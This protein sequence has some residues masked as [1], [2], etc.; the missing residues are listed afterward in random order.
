[1]LGPGPGCAASVIPRAQGAAARGALVVSR[2]SVTLSH[3]LSA[4]IGTGFHSINKMINKPEAKMP[5]R[6]KL[7]FYRRK[8]AALRKQADCLSSSC[9]YPHCVLLRMQA[10]A[11][12][13]P[14]FAQGMKLAPILHITLKNSTAQSNITIWSRNFVD[15]LQNYIPG[16]QS[17]LSVNRQS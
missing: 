2:P 1:M 7:H 12:L 9:H 17:C 15:S 11:Q 8:V 3:S 13:T 4:N 14:I 6:S 5:P 16:M 10:Q